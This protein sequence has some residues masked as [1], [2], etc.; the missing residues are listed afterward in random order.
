[1]NHPVTFLIGVLCGIAA[2]SLGC[3]LFMMY[4]LDEYGHANREVALLRQRVDRLRCRSRDST[5]VEPEKYEF[6]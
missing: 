4:L 6:V 5:P 1:M 2:A 3:G